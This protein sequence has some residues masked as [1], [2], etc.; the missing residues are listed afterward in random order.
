MFAM[1]LVVLLGVPLADH[2][3]SITFVKMLA[4]LLV[5]PLAD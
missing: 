5:V 1:M 4:M 3:D 2:Y